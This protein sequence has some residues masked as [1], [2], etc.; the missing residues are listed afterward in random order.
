LIIGG[1]KFLGRHLTRAAQKNNHEVT[2]FNRGKYSREEFKNVEQ[3]HG[4][5]N[6]DLGN[7]RGKTW[8]AVI[9]TCGYLPQTVRK[10]A[11]FLADKVNQYVFISSGSVYSDTSK[12][13]YDESTKTG[14]LSDEQRE[15][16]E[17]FDLNQELNGIVLGESYGALKKLCEVEAESA[18][19]NRVLSVRAGMIVGTFDWTDR[20]AYWVMRV[21]RGG[22]II[23]PG[24][25]ENFVQLIDARDLSEWIVKTVEENVTGIFNVTSKSLDLTFGKMLGEMKTATGSD[26]EFVWADEKFLTEN[27]VAPW[28]EMPFYLPES[29][30]NLRNF[31]TM[32]VDK[33][34]AKGLKLRPLRETILDVLN[35]REKQDFE[36]KAGIST[37][38]EKYLLEKLHKQ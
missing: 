33:A 12:A 7:L 27:N 38:R 32:N 26:A 5:R 3:I 13:N 36:L 15:K 24:K 4:D 20:F 1:T 21:G 17:N 29:D 23:A 35:W 28:S 34:L 25:P 16:F 11:E 10:S 22:E 2:L 37:E 31:L 14:K 30:E 19:P 6:S 8:D 18:M 9:D